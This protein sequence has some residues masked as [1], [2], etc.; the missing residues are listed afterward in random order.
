MS[1]STYI[2]GLTASQQKLYSIQL[3]HQTASYQQCTNNITQQ[4]SPPH[5]PLHQGHYKY[6]TTLG[7]QP[8]TPPKQHH[9]Q[10][11][12]PPQQRHYQTQTPPQQQQQHYQS[13][14]SLNV[15]EVGA[16]SI[17]FLP[18]HDESQ[19][20]RCVSEKCDKE[21]HIDSRAF[22]HPFVIMNILDRKNT[23]EEPMVFGLIVST[24]GSRLY[25]QFPVLDS[26]AAPKS[27]SD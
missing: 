15:G 16:G 1:Q 11:Q 2:P 6:Q 21:H 4:N 14:S 17:V 25:S 20:Y 22:K 8:Q 7:Y 18:Q 26:T 23:N 27:P 24:S 13:S 3:L 9:Y 12:T 10:A 19:S 5:S